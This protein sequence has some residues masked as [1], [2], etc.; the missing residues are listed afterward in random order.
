MVYLISII[1]VVFDI[2]S[3]KVLITVHTHDVIRYISD[4]SH[5]GVAEEKGGA[6]LLSL[7]HI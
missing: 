2:Y 4:D 6:L 5:D 7:I 1:M 3:Y